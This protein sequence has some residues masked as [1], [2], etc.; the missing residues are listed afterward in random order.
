MNIINYREFEFQNL[1]KNITRT[2]DDTENY[3]PVCKKVKEWYIY[4]I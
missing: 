1:R 4:V 2:P 3:M